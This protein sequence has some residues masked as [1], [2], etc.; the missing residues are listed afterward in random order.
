MFGIGMPELILIFVIALIV[1]GPN[2]LPQLAKKLGRTMAEFKRTSDDLMNQIQTELDAVGNE[3]PKPADT[4]PPYTVPGAEVAGETVA[5]P[6]AEGAPADPVEASAHAAPPSVGAEEH[7]AAAE[8]PGGGAA[9]DGPPAGESTG[10]AEKR[11]EAGG[12]LSPAPPGPE[13]PART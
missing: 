7:V 9:A 5:A 13:S 3:E 10:D 11:A 12:N 6:A 8:A 4:T 1:F 2:E